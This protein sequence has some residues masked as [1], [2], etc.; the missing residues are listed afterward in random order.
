MRVKWVLS[1]A[2]RASGRLLDRPTSNRNCR[3]GMP[4]P[5]LAIWPA[6]S[7]GHRMLLRQISLWASLTLVCLA[8][9][10]NAQTPSV[11]QSPLAG[12]R[13]KLTH[14]DLSP[15]GTLAL[16]PELARHAQAATGSEAGEAAFLRAAAAT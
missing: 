16:L 10:A 4:G 11:K 7:R 5:G 3:L 6:E 8:V 15:Q 13:E 12:V 14:Y 9:R 2:M 1:C